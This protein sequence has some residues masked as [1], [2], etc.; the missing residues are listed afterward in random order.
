MRNSGCGGFAASAATLFFRKGPL[1]YFDIERRG[2]TQPLVAGQRPNCWIS[3]VPAGG[4][5][6]APEG[7]A[8]CTCPYPIQG[9]VAMYPKAQDTHDSAG[10]RDR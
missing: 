9:S 5:V 8:G 6:L 4:I 10:P 2:A 1:S 3:F 7:S